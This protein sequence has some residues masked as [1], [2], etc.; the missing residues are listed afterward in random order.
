M[1][2]FVS[3]RLYFIK[4]EFFEIVGEKYL[5]TNKGDTQRPHYYAL[6]DSSTELLWV[7]PCS[8][9]IEKYK[10]IIANKE[11]NGKKHRT[12]IRNKEKTIRKKEKRLQIR[13][14][15]F[16]MKIQGILIVPAAMRPYSEAVMNRKAEHGT[17]KSG[18]KQKAEHGAG[19]PGMNRKTGHE[20][21]KRDELP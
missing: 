14:S 15:F 17:G 3:G 12:K 18:I 20:T 13:F 16:K 1:A 11:K 4:D 5:K 10:K 7:I 21:G 8:S 2:D 6:R 19:K 9:Q